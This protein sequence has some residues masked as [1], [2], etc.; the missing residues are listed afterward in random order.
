[1]IEALQKSCRK[2]RKSNIELLRILCAFFV[3]TNHFCNAYPDAFELSSDFESC[4]AVQA[5]Y[6]LTIVGVNMF[7]LITGY[8][9]INATQIQIGKIAKLF[10]MLC[11]YH[12]VAYVLEVTTNV[13]EFSFIG[14][15]MHIIPFSYYVFICATLYILSPFVNRLIE[16]ISKK[17]YQI[18]LIILLLL[19]SVYSTLANL[20]EN[21]T[22]HQ[23][24]DIFTVAQNGTDRGFTIVNFMMI[25]LIGGYLRKYGVRLGKYKCMITYFLCAIV[26]TIGKVALPSAKALL[27]YDSIFVILQSISLF[28]F[29]VEIEFTSKTVN[30]IA[31]SSFG[32]YL[33]NDACML[34]GCK[35][36]NISEM[37]SSGV[38][39]YF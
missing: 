23:W 15:I 7:V 30:V 20:F 35:Y 21:I 8:F 9:M 3:L 36:F 4:I 37:V 22:Q 33:L 13:Y 31:K 24:T 10:I 17:Q 39:G 25:Y 12:L 29:F 19:F 6:S 38:G 14:L 5:I 26:T 18:L 32:V 34:I 11:G 28:L 16:N 2:P 27:Y 1:M